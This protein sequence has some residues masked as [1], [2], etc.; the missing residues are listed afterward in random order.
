MNN[1]KSI[2][3]DKII[4]DL[5]NNPSLYQE[6][7]EK[8]GQV[9]GQVFSDENRSQQVKIDQEAAKELRLNRDVLNLTALL[10]RHKIKP[11]VGCSLAC[12]SGRLERQLL[13]QGI[14][15]RFHGIDLA[16]DALEEARKI[17]KQQQLDIT[18]EQEDINTIQL[19]RQAYDLVVTQNCLHHVLRLEHLADEI[20]KALK[21]D[22]VLWIHDYIGETQFQYSDERLEIA[23]KILAVLPEKLRF[24]HVNNCQTN[25]IFVKDPGTLI[26]PFESIRSQEI[27]PIFLNKFDIIE[28]FEFNS[29]LHL[30]CPVGTRSAF[31]HSEESRSIF[32][33]LFLLDRLLVD[34]GIILPAA[35]QYLLKPK[36][37]TI[38][39]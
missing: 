27:M 9:W 30:V 37:L 16:A 22:G 35:G 3:A 32:E 34:T 10:R 24:N 20:A 36:T 2:K 29:I 21:P 39:N 15:Q 19:E 26:S 31:L 23:N 8:E 14:C 5:L 6:M 28:K 4:N 12:G 7:A 25:K 11:T 13:L 1:D 38:I 33:L 17:A 18:Y